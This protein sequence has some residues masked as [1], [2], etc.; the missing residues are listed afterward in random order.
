M[1]TNSL[2]EKADMIE[3]RYRAAVVL[4]PSLGKI[5]VMGGRN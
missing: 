5:F 1:I 2:K 4:E 3:K